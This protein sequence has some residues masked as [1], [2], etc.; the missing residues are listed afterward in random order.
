MRITEWVPISKTDVPDIAE[1]GEKVLIPIN[2]K[3][4][5]LNTALQK[6]VTFQ[7]NVN[8]ESRTV[9]VRHGVALDIKL[10]PAVRGKPRKVVVVKT[11]PAYFT[12]L[13]WESPDFETVRIILAFSANGTWQDTPPTGDVSVMLDIEGSS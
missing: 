12:S 2:A 3:L 1:W 11:D 5:E 4:L 9:K 13:K 8:G 6:R 10:T 7:D